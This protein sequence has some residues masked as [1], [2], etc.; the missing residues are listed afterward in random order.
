MDDLTSRDLKYHKRKYSDRVSVYV[1]VAYIVKCVAQILIV[2]V[3]SI[4]FLQGNNK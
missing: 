4:K 1:P 2:N 3:I